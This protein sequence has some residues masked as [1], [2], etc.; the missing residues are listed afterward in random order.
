MT[1]REAA[2][3]SIYT[4]YA[5]L[6]GDD[7]DELYKYASELLGRPAETLDF[8]VNAD[9]LRGL[10]YSD[11]YEICKHLERSDKSERINKD[12]S[13]MQSD[14]ESCIRLEDKAERVD[15]KTST[16]SCLLLDLGNLRGP[17]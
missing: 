5:L 12:L 8:A 16:V 1:V 17:G 3:I 7:L 10:A 15:Q 9:Y 4:G 2:I 14:K 11:L 13:E 6:E